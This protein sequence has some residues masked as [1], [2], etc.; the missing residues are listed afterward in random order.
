MELSTNDLLTVAGNGAFVWLVLQLLVK[1]W[2]KSDRPTYPAVMN[3]A[4]V[5]V[6]LI[7]AVAAAAVTPLEYSS[8][9]QA[10]LVGLGGAATAIGM[11]EVAGNTIAALKQNLRAPDGAQ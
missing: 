3:A 5:L 11:H 6:G 7:G 2:L 4:A 8:I 1:P 10:V 9:L